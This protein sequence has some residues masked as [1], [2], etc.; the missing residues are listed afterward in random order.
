[1]VVGPTQRQ[2]KMAAG[3]WELSNLGTPEEVVVA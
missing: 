1:M 3:V 2:A